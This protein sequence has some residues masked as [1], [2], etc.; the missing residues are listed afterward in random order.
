MFPMQGVLV[1]SLVKELDP[2]PTKEAAV[3]FGPL[4]TICLIKLPLYS[5]KN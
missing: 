4:V 2:S 1:P 3:E 5:V